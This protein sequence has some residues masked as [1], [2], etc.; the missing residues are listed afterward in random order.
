M[1]RPAPRLFVEDPLSAGAEVR[2]EAGPAHYLAQVLRLKPGADVRLFNGRDGEWRAALTEAAKRAC[3]LSVETQT[4]DQQTPPPLTLAFA[5]LKK[6]PMDFLIQK[7]TELGATALQPVLTERTE[8][9]RLNTERIGAQLREAAE[10]C[11]RLDIPEIA[12]PVKLP[13]FLKS[14]PASGVVWAGDETGG[15]LPLAAHAEDAPNP[16]RHP[17]AILIGP[18]GGFTAGE[19]ASLDGLTFVRRI[20]LGP[21]I[22]RAET[23]ALAALTCW[24]GLFGDWPRIN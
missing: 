11:E 12:A 8:T 21:R 4:R 17:H 15:G 13:A 18:E 9:Q 24:Q 5:P 16:A 20:H 2:L 22:L 1:S 7:A 19:L 14:W 23:A 3:A 10:Q 6:S